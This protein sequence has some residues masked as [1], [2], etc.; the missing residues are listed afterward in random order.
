MNDLQIKLCSNV[1]NPAWLEKGLRML[2]INNQVLKENQQRP[3]LNEHFIDLAFWV[4][5]SAILKYLF[6]QRVLVKA[7]SDYVQILIQCKY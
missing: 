7:C 3:R 5:P 2:N 6:Q 4:G 1:A